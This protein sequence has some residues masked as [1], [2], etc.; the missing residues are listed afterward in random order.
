MEMNRKIK[1]EEKD[2]EGVKKV[3]G[4]ERG[5]GE[6]TKEQKKRYTKT[7]ERERHKGR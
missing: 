7:K 5:K 6:E 1:R 4:S 3:M 2:E